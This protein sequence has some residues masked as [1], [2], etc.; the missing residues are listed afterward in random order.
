L[1]HKVASEQV[2]SRFIKIVFQMKKKIKKYIKKFLLEIFYIQMSIA[3]FNFTSYEEDII[4][5]FL[6]S[7]SVIYKKN[8]KVT[9]K[10]ALGTIYYH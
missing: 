1:K 3:S 7:K 8:K 6:I 2:G 4:W 9:I 5:F 10:R